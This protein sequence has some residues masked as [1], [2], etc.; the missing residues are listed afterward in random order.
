MLH[1]H[2]KYYF[3]HIKL[4]VC[5][6]VNSQNHDVWLNR[7]KEQL[8]GSINLACVVLKEGIAGAHFTNNKFHIRRKRMF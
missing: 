8:V 2:L 5:L 4:T 3:L 6:I 7:F 1:L